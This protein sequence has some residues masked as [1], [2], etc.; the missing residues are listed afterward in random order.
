MEIKQLVLC[1]D[2]KYWKDNGESAPHW[3]PC[4]EMGTP[5]DW[6][7]ASGEAKDGGGDDE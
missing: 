6:F 3:L 5:Q 7:C 1:I 4:K 2:C